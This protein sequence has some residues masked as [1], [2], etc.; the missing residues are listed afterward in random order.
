M[1][2]SFTPD[3]TWPFV[4]NIDGNFHNFSIDKGTGLALPR[5]IWRG[6]TDNQDWINNSVLKALET[7]NTFWLSQAEKSEIETSIKNHE[8]IWNTPAYTK[9]LSAIFPNKPIVFPYLENYDNALIVIRRL[10]ELFWKTVR[11]PKEDEAIA[12]LKKYNHLTGSHHWYFDELREVGECGHA[13]LDGSVRNDK[14][15][16]ALRAKTNYAGSGMNHRGEGFSVIP[17]FG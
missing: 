15:P 6:V 2:I 13:W 7:H 9:F 3:Q 14:A 1:W 12:A 5:N 8:P 16:Y 4:E 11:L 10:C 17:V